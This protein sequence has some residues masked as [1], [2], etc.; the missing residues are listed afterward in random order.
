MARFNWAEVTREDVFEAVRIFDSEHPDHPE[1]RSTF[2][3]IEGHRYPAKHIRGMAYQVHFGHRR[4]NT[5]CDAK[6][7]H[8]YP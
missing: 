2:L 1:P 8:R 7:C 4:Q 5:K 6:Q 3:V